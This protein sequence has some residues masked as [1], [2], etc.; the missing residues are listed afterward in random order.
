MNTDLFNLMKRFE[1]D[2]HV[3]IYDGKLA[4]EIVK[5]PKI[6]K[7]RKNNKVIVGWDRNKKCTIL[8]KTPKF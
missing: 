4:R 2:N 8:F 5:K 1:K 7:M 3:I 6:K